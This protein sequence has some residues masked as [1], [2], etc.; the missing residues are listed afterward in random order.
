[1]KLSYEDRVYRMADTTHIIRLE[2]SAVYRIR[3][4]IP[5]GDDVIFVE[6]ESGLFFLDLDVYT[7]EEAARMERAMAEIQDTNYFTK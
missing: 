1:M 3:D 5:L 2:D 4:I 7:L 6:T